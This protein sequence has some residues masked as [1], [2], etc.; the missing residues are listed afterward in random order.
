[1]KSLWKIIAGV[2]FWQGI[3]LSQRKD[4]SRKLHE[5]KWR[6]KLSVLTQEL[7]NLN[8]D[9]IQHITP[10]KEQMTVE[11]F[12]H[13][14]EQTKQTITNLAEQWYTMSKEWYNNVVSHME[15]W[16]HALQQQISDQYSHL[17]KEYHISKHITTLLDNVT[18]LKD[19]RMPTNEH[20]TNK[21]DTN[22]QEDMTTKSVTKS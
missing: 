7:R 21:H 10:T 14:L 11:W 6:E 12:H 4:I 1:M 15:D 13:A 2:V 19:K 16:L 17:D 3:A 9:I 20:D 8:K 18:A 22:K 5:A